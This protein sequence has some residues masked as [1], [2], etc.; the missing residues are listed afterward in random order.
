MTPQ[1]QHL[2]KIQNRDFLDPCCSPV[3]VWTAQLK[4]EVDAIWQGRTLGPDCFCKGPGI[5]RL[6]YVDHTA[7]V[8]MIHY[9]SANS[10]TDKTEISGSGRVLVRLDLSECCLCLRRF[11]PVDP[12]FRRVTWENSLT[13]KLETSLGSRVILF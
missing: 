5:F 13:Q 10:V 1:S 7:S 12:A 4:G 8:A 3:V 6:H 2:P 9:W 11:F